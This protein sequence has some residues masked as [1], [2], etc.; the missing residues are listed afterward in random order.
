MPRTPPSLAAGIAVATLLVVACGDD[1]GG[2]SA[3]ETTGESTPVVS[4]D[5]TATDDTSQT[6]DSTAT[7]D[8][9]SGEGSTSDRG[10]AIADA[11]DDAPVDADV[12]SPLDLRDK[13]VDPSSVMGL[14]VDPA[15]LAS[16]FKLRSFIYPDTTGAS[17]I[18]F[19]VSTRVGVSSMEQ[20]A[21]IGVALDSQLTA[22]KIAT[23]VRDEIQPTDQYRIQSAPATGGMIRF[24]AAPKDSEAGLPDWLVA[25]MSTDSMP[26]GERFPGSRFVNVGMI[27]QPMDQADVAPPDFVDARFGP[28]TTVTS[29]LRYDFYGWSYGYQTQPTGSVI[30]S[31]EYRFVTTDKKIT[32]TADDIAA[33]IGP[34]E[35][36]KD[37]KQK[38]TF[39]ANG[40]DW[41]IT[42]QGN[43]A[44]ITLGA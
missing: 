23:M 40:V 13:P 43:A 25:I 18:S 14:G 7:D 8:T 26:G 22:E 33:E 16:E 41:Y 21:N 5:S 34:V 36:R 31:F 37:T 3:D 28:I 2:S 11:L 17:I 6:D 12:G 39:S 1:D 35:N 27:G 20:S 19:Q 44:A 29:A 30:E 38:I 4:A 15:T 10:A 32:K 24:N 42:P 9:A